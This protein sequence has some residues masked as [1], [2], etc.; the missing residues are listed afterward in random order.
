MRMVRNLAATLL[1]AAAAPLALAPAALARA[2]DTVKLT[3][4]GGHF[5]PAEVEAPAGRR[6]RIEVTNA[7]RT[8]SEFES[9]DLRAEK[10]VVPGGTI[11]V[12]AG[13][14]KP[15]TY[16]FFDDYHPDDAHGTLTAVAGQP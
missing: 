9:A 2:D 11:H 7:D 12:F 3:I 13:P 16:K 6:L 14:L 5:T 8:P 4:R 10:I 15:G 1:A